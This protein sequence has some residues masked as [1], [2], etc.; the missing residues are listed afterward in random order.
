MDSYSSTDNWDI[1]NAI[2]QDVSSGR[3]VSLTLNNGAAI[4]NAGGYV[5]GAAALISEWGNSSDMAVFIHDDWKVTDRLNLNAGV[6]TEMSRV[7]LTTETGGAAT[8]ATP[9]NVYD[10]YQS[11]S[12]P[13]A[14]TTRFDDTFHLN[15]YVIGGNFKLAKNT[16]VFADESY[17]GST[18]N[19]DELRGTNP[20][21]PPGNMTVHQYEIGLKTATPLYSANVTYYHNNIKNQFQSQ[22]TNAG[23]SVN[24]I[25]DARANALTYELAI[26]PIENLQVAFSGDLLRAYY[27]GFDNSLS[28]GINGNA[29]VRQPGEQ[30][31]LTPT[32]RIPLGDYSLKF[33]GTW[34]YVGLRYSDQQNTQVLPSYQTLD[35]GAILDVG[36]KLEFRL[37]GTN[38]TNELGITEGNVHGV[39]S[40]TLNG[41]NLVIGR[42]L[43]GRELKLSAEYRF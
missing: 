6:R 26:R 25:G 3:P 33:Y 13:G 1:G 21:T 2:A 38:L 43:F 20:V 24:T 36:E 28:P 31:R 42:P 5:N 12:A 29:E 11:Y 40:G 14:K 39:N 34:T 7:D 41:Q 22:I 8:N 10:N 32:Y 27:Y 30:F 17:G 9:L 18:P 23:A 19:F 37:T 16:S 4:T 15:S 35:A